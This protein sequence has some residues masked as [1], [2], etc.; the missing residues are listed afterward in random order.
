MTDSAFERVLAGGWRGPVFA[1]LVAFLAGLPGV[2]AMPA[3]DRD[4]A[5][6]AE[7]TA[8]M[9]E[10][11]DFVSINFQD[12]PRNKKPVGI[13][14]LQAAAVAVASGVEKRQIWA[15]RLPSLLGAMAAA[16]ACAWGA[17]PLLGPRGGAI[18]GAIL[19]SC[20]L[21]S[22]EA[23]IAKTDAALCG[24]VTLT[25]AALAR[26]YAASRGEA[27]AGIGTKMVFW[28]GVAVSILLKGPIGPMVAGLTLLGLWVWDQR[29]PWLASLGWAWGLVVVLL[30]VGPWALAVTIKTDGGFWTG[31]VMGDMVSKIKAGQESHGAPPGL[32]LLLA[33][34]LVFPAT[35]LLPAALV[36]GWKDRAGA[37]A[38]FAFCWLVPSWVVFELAP[39]K[40][41]HYTLPLYGALA[42][43]MAA[44]LTQPIGRIARISGTALSLLIGA[45]LAAAGVALAKLYG[46]G[47]AMGWAITA[48]VLALGAVAA[49]ATAILVQ[50]HALPALMAALGLGLLA[51]DALAAGLAPR[52][53][54]L[55]VSG[56]AAAALARAGIDPRNGVTPGPVAVAGFEEPSI[57]FLLGAHTELGTGQDAASAIADGRPAIVEAHKLRPFFAELKVE[58]AAAAPVAE[59]KG[60]D[61]SKGRTVDL[62][63]YRSME[64]A[65]ETP[66]ETPGETP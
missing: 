59:V 9:L 24:A 42:W 16:A 55:W 31:A 56:R 48:G 51:H 54:P 20:L 15:Y 62:F 7:A 27:A 63:L 66:G 57:V 17:G 11:R 12:E 21:L 6:F 61:Y 37:A 34:L 46:S 10:T 8:Q 58:D 23:F 28:L 18:A 1:A 60:L 25:M 39:T 33:P 13:H 38:R 36:L 3:L 47:A 19:G 40:L 41:P 29:K 5:R 44:A 64:S 35:A 53:Q 65:R 43:L 49:G 4:E 14:W 22:T 52:L 45:A 50:R 32:H 30:I 26:I 2:L